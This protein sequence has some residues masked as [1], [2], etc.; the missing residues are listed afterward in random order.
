MKRVGLLGPGTFSEESAQH[1]LDQ[2]NFHFIPYKFITDVIDSTISL[3]VDFGVVPVE[4][5][6]EGS[7]SAHLDLLVLQQQL[8]IKAEWVYPIEMHLIGFTKQDIQLSKPSFT[9]IKKIF[10]HHVVPAQCSVFMKNFLAH[11]EFEQVSNTAEGARLVALANDPQVAAIG[12]RMSA[13]LYELEIL[14]QD[15]QNHKDNMTRFLLLGDESPILPITN[16]YKTTLLVTLPEDFPGA[17]YQMLSAFALRK[18]NLSKIESRPTKKKLGS[19][20]FYID[21]EDSMISTDLQAAIQ[22]IEK[23]GCQVR[24]LGSYPSFTYHSS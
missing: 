8:M 12:P 21:L 7:V 3:E 18:I 6:M 24:N 19:Y 5:T 14:A 20:Y 10:S 23:M 16:T 4:N 2:R 17:L 13:Q 15:I 1:F 11:A 22:E 9:H